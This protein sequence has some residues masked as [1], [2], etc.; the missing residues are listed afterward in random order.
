MDTD[1][2]S[3]GYP[4]GLLIW[5]TLKRTSLL[6]FSDSGYT[7]TPSS[8]WRAV[9]LTILC[10][11]LKTTHHFNISYH[12]MQFRLVLRA[13][14]NN[15]FSLVQSHTVHVRISQSQQVITHC[16]CLNPLVMYSVSLFQIQIFRTFSG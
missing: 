9:K 8:K 10:T 7:V 6:K 5:I 11:L 4:Q 1:P 13:M 15:Q 12:T 16:I 14:C 3:M 2:Q